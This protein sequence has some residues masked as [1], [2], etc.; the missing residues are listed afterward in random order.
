MKLWK[1][2]G[3]MSFDDLIEYN[4]NELSKFAKEES[5]HEDKPV[6]DSGSNESNE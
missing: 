1:Y 5:T 6:D 3:Q 4:V 2:Y